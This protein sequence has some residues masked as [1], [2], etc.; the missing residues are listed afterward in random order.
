MKT[1]TKLILGGIVVASIVA[2]VYF[3]NIKPKSATN[4]SSNGKSP[5]KKSRKPEVLLKTSVKTLNI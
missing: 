5:K 2:G 1:S 4:E 3:W